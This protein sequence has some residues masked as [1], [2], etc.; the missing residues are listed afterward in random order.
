MRPSSKTHTD[1]NPKPNKKKRLENHSKGDEKE[2]KERGR[3]RADAWEK[4]GCI[5]TLATKM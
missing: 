2:K 1:K 3:E 4:M 5:T